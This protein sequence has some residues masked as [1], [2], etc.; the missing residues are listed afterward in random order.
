MTDIFLRESQYVYW[1]SKSTKIIVSDHPKHDTASHFPYFSL[2][3]LNSQ[4]F[5]VF[6]MSGH[7]AMNTFPYDTAKCYVISFVQSLSIPVTS[8]LKYRQTTD[9]ATRRQ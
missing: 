2:S 6:Q 5:R 9:C 8:Q 7:P 3:I 1:H 4:L